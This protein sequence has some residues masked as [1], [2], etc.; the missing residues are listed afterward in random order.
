MAYIKKIKLPNND[1]V[2]DIYDAGAPRKEELEKYATT[3]ELNSKS[4]STLASA[5]TYADSAANKVKSDL[6]NGAGTAYDT[7]KELGDLIEEG[8]DAIEALE[9]IASGKA[10]A[11]A[12]TSHTGNKSNPHGVTASQI[13]AVPTSRTVNGKALSTNISLS[14]S[15]VGADASGAANTALV[16]AKAYTDAEITEWIGDKTVSVQIEDAFDDAITG[17]SVSGKIITYTKGDGTTGTITTQDTD[18]KYTHPT[19]TAK[20]AGLYK[21][22]VDGTGHVSGTTAVAKSDITALGIPAQDTTYSAATTSAAGLMSASDKSKLDGIASGANNYTYTLP[23][24]TSSALGGVKVGSNITNSSGTIS[25]TKSNVTSAL[26]YTPP[27]TN[28]TYSDATTSTAGLMSAS[29]KTKLDGIATGANKITIDSALSSTSTNPVQNKV[30]NTALAG[31]SDT[32]HTHNYAGSSSAGGAATSADKINTDAGS[33]TNPVYFSNGIPVQTTYT[34]GA[35][36]PSG[37]KFTDTVYTHPT[38]AGNKHIPSGGSS[39]QILRWSASGTAVWGA[40]NNTTYSD[41]TQSAAGLMS[42]SDKKKLDG[43]ASGANNYTYTLPTASSSTLGGVKTTSTVTSTSGLTACPIISGVPYYKDTNTTYSLSSFGITA[44]ATELNK[45]DGVTAT[46]T[47]L[48][49]VDG[50]TSNIQTQLNNKMSKTESDMTALFASGKT[51]LSS[52]QFGDS[53]PAAGNAG[54]IFFKKVVE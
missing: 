8:Q 31:K 52:N 25:L 30:I 24:A 22:T 36:V 43:I 2:Y 28:T 15:D 16:N 47:E 20:S 42:A 38:T 3:E 46:T 1:Q 10:D 6:L 53:L 14:A 33:A 9:T 32:G 5:K 17:L 13:S 35:S 54:R 41:A 7:L 51:I 39:G 12:L 19:Y 37:A 34:L 44:T 26:G 49:Y 45:M 27:T 18:T 4:D 48:N 40:D 23:A 29:D 50:V 11:S 21:V